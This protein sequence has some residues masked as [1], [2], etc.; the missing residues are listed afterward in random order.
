MRV[1]TRFISLF[2]VISPYVL[3]S[4]A[5]KEKNYLRKTRGE[6]LRR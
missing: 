5:I 4:T 1:H 2:C 6:S 3:V